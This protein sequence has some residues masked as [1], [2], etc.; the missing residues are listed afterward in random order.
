LTT[1]TTRLAF[2]SSLYLAMKFSVAAATLVS[3]VPAVLGLTINT[4]TNVVQC[5]PILLNWADG[6]APYFLSLIPPG[7]VSA[8]AIKTFPTQQGTS[9]T[10]T[11]D[12]EAN[13]S[14]NLALKDN[15]G[16]TAYSDIVTVQAS[17]DRTCL[18]GGSS[19]ISSPPNTGA[20]SPTNTATGNSS[21]SGG[22]STK[23][24]T[25]STSTGSS[26]SGNSGGAVGLT[27]SS[28]S[29]AGIVGAIAALF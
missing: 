7:Q 9:L 25:G 19:N 29:V 26:S 17:G 8:A 15:T 16:A 18:T 1:T 20:S 11:V 28:F 24:S 12:L 23:T 3:L 10:W 27:L 6:T 21:G 22:S 5:Q 14:F 4:P 13:T 2:P